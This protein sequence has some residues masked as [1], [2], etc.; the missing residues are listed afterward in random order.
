ME[1][2][3]DR[4]RNGGRIRSNP[5]M[6]VKVRLKA[7]QWR[8]G[9]NITLAPSPLLLTTTILLLLCSVVGIVEGQ[10]HHDLRKGLQEKSNANSGNNKKQA[11]LAL[12]TKKFKSTARA[13]NKIKTI[14]LR[15]SESEVFVQPCNSELMFN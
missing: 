6:A 13:S 7:V 11:Y 4:V 14:N 15:V 8:R 2:R 3:I 10:Q 12:T 9:K 1:L 5:G